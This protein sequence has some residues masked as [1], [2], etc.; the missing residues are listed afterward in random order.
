MRI[1]DFLSG[2]GSPVAYHPRLVPVCGSVN[3]TIL[4]CQLLYWTGKECSHD[5]FIYKT[6]TE[7]TEETGLSRREQETARRILRL[8]DLLHEK[9]DHLAHKLF[10]RVNGD[11]LHQIFIQFYPPPPGEWRIPPSGNGANVHPGMADSA[12]GLYRHRLP[13]ETTNKEK[14]DL[15]FSW[16][17]DKTKKDYL[18]PETSPNPK[19]QGSVARLAKDFLQ[20]L[21]P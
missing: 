19:T 8:R 4:T 18:N 6:Q 3:A 5:G 7:L 15:S 9:E 10:Y 20:S 12:I 2:L 17:P 14:S 13:T 21:K 16:A 1:S 11:K